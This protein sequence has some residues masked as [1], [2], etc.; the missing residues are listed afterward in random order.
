MIPVFSALAGFSPNCCAVL[1]QMEHWADRSADT[2]VSAAKTNK[3]KHHRFIVI[4]LEW[5]RYGGILEGKNRKSFTNFGLLYPGKASY[6]SNVTGV[7]SFL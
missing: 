4:A 2:S 3:I 7:S 6:E 1:V 5:Q